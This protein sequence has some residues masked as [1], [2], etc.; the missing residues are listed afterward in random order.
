MRESHTRIRHFVRQIRHDVWRFL[1]DPE[2]KRS[3]WYWV[4]LSLVFF[5]VSVLT[6]ALR[7]GKASE[8]FSHV[9]LCIAYGAAA[10]G[11]FLGMFLWHCYKRDHAERKHG[12]ARL[13]AFLSKDT[14][15]NTVSAFILTV[16]M[17]TL[18]LAVAFIV[19]HRDLLQFAVENPG[20]LF[21]LITGSGTLVG[22]YFAA[23]SIL[24]M[25]HTI[26]SFPQLVD[27]I[28]SLVNGAS[29]SKEGVLFFAY[30]IQPG[31]WNVDQGTSDR[32]KEAL[33]NPSV[34]VQAILLKKV[35]HDEWLSKFVGFATLAK[36]EITDTRRKDFITD[37]EDILRCLAGQACKCNPKRPEFTCQPIGLDYA[38]MPGY[39]FFVSPDRAILAVTVEMPRIGNP[40]PGL[41]GMINVEALGFETTDRRIIQMLRREFS[42]YKRLSQKP[43]KVGV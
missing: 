23:H 4:L 39:Y 27:R 30:T 17:T 14:L 34:K 42:R 32:L 19:I 21:A 43:A 5:V 9:P 28:A 7:K 20:G 6:H 37:C 31:A 10:V 24:E 38:Q 33:T 18:C 11:M 25:K 8:L 35:A 3:F 26:A 13:L 16:V 1:S 12:L 36:G 15:V 22:T 29:E 41:K 40:P 2:F